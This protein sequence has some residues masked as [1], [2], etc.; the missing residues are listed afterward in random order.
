MLGSCLRRSLQKEELKPALE[1]M[2]KPG[3]VQLCSESLL[4]AKKEE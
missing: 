1:D 3:W 2:A 4:S